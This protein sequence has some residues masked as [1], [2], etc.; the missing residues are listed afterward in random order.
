MP[1]SRV[2]SSLG[3]FQD[4]L[5]PTCAAMWHRRSISRKVS[6]FILL[7][8]LGADC[9]FCLKLMP[10]LM[11]EELT[12]AL[13]IKNRQYL[14]ALKRWKSTQVMIVRVT[15]FA[16]RFSSLNQLLCKDQWPVLLKWQFS[17]FSLKRKYGLQKFER[18][19]PSKFRR[20][21]NLILEHKNL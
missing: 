2:G 6:F 3:S 19:L 4:W 17:S 8:D 16:I 9:A 14:K 18:I 20:F 10:Y 5:D 1:Q 15:L 21:R 11:P 12:S 7:L 13:I